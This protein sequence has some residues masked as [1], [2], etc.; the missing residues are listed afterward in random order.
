MV[1]WKVRALPPASIYPTILIPR[2]LV[3]QL[4]DE[5]FQLVIAHELCHWKRWD[6]QINL[7]Q[8]VL[9]VIYFYNPAVWFAK[10]LLRRLREEAVDDAVLIAIAAPTDR[11]SN[12]LL[13]VAAHSLRPVEINVRLIGIL[14]SRKALMSRIHRLAAVP[15]PN[16]ARLGLWGFAAVV[17]IGVALLPMAASRRAIADKPV[18]GSSAPALTEKPEKTAP[19]AALSVRI[20]DKK[21]TSVSDARV[22]LIDVSTGNVRDPGSLGLI[23]ESITRTAT[24]S[25]C[26]TTLRDSTANRS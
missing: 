12:T 2:W 7:L 22:Q 18:D 10:A 5:Q 8:T 15:L 13:D 25:S 4:D 1:L 17:T 24:R 14:E 11:Y 6:L 3:N 9:Q 21:G 16:S 23:Q 26:S 19:T 20:T